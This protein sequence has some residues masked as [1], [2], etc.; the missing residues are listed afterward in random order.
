MAM[1][2]VGGRLVL[3]DTVVEVADA[4]IS[5]SDAGAVEA[6]G[7]RYFGETGP[8]FEADSGAT[9]RVERAQVR[10]GKQGLVSGDV[11]LTCC[12][13]GR[14]RRS[15]AASRGACRRRRSPSP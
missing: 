10:A 11:V 8:T 4:A 7:G 3:A 2:A 9:V 6:H 15:R 12:H 14:S 13:E 5:A 1:E